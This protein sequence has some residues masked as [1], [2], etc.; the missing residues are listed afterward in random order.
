MINPK[1]DCLSRN[2]IG[3]AD[4]LTNEFKMPYEVKKQANRNGHTI[5]AASSRRTKKFSILEEKK[6]DGRLQWRRGPEWENFYA[7]KGV[8]ACKYGLEGLRAREV[9]RELFKDVFNK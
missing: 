7:I 3:L 2:E 5:K 9:I 6:V 8:E 1:Y 4:A